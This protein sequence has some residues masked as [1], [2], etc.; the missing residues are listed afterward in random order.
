MPAGKPGVGKRWRGLIAA[1]V[2]CAGLMG[3]TAFAAFPNSAPNDPDYAPSEQGTQATC[4]QR[5]ADDEQHYLYSFMPKCSPNATDA[6]NS[7]G[8]SLDKAWRK[9]TPGNGHTVIAYIEGGI[10]W[11]HDPK[12]LADKVF[13]NKGELPPPT[14]P[15]K[16]KKLCPDALCAA[17]YSDTKDANKNGVVDPEDIIVR[18]SNRRD[19][20]SNGYVDDI[21]GWD[22]YND[23]NDPATVDSTYDHAN[24]QQ[25]QAAAQTDNDFKGAGVCPGCM[26]LPIK[27]G[28]EALDRTDDLAQAWLYAADLNADVLVSTTADLG[29]SSFMRQAVERVW[30]KGTIMAESSNDF[31]SIDHQGGMFWQHVLPGNG[32]V[33]NTHGFDIAPNSA[34]LQNQL[35]TTY[36]SR[37]GYTSW[38]T[39]NMFSAAT[40]GGT[41]SESVPTVG[42]VMAMVVAY[43]KK[44]AKQ[45][46]IKRPL[47]PD[48]AIQVVRATASDVAQNPCAP[49]CWPAKP[50]WDMQYGYGRPNVYK[51]MQ[52]ISKGNIPPEA[53]IDSP[54]W[55]SL[56]DPTKTDGVAVKGHIEA[57]RSKKPYTWKLQFAPG[58]E[59]SK[60][61]FMTAAQGKRRQALDGKLGQIDFSRLPPS[62]WNEAQ[63]PFH[64]SNTKELETNDQYTVTIRLRVI[65]AKGRMAEDR[66]AIAVHHDPTLR[67]GFPKRIGPGGE[68]QPVLADLQGRGREAIIFGDSDGR[69]HALS[70]HGRELPGFPVHTKPTKVTR[71]HRGI[72]PGY[73]PIFTN[74]A[75][76]D[77]KGNGKQW[78]VAT[79]STGRT[80]V[81][82]AH[83]HLMKGWPKGIA[84]GV[85]KPA[86]P[87]P[88]RPFTRP[89]VMGASAPPVLANLDGDRQLEIVQAGWDGYLHAWN[90]SGKKVKGWPVKVTLPPGTQPP[91]GMVRI[92][93]HK[94]DLPPTLAELDGDPT[95]ELVQR[96]QYAFTPGAG[97]QVGNGGIS[98]VV[99]YNSDG[100]RVPGFLLQ[101]RALA[102]Y[103]GSAQEFITEGV[104]SPATA[105][106]DGD[107]KTEIAS[108]A[109]IFTPT[110]LYNTDGSLRGAYGP[111][112][113]GAVSI[114]AGNP[115]TLIDVLHGNLPDDVPVNFATAGAFAS[116]GPGG[117]LAYVEPGSGSAS[118]VGALLL[119]GSGTPINSY[120]RAYG[121]ASLN[122]LPGFPTKAQGLDFL[123][124]P[125][126]AD[127]TGDGRP[128]VIQGGDSS[129]L[130]AFTS[131]GTQAPGF[132]KFTT[133]WVVFGPSVGDLDGNG[134][135][136]VAAATREGYLMVW[137]TRGR[138][139]TNDQWWS[140]RH[141][142]RNTGM[143]G[144]DTRPP[145][146]LRRVRSLHHRVSFKAP[147]DDWY[148]G[149]VDHYRVA[150]VRNP[151]KRH[152]H[153]KARSFPATVAAGKTQKLELPRRL[154]P[155]SMW[156]VDEAG[157]RGRAY[158]FAYPCPVSG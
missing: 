44:A 26:L 37:S 152:R 30:D 3:G 76:G 11:H 6:E 86:I 128:E 29:Y 149:K 139:D 130:H 46:K 63:N 126:V 78:I 47:S 80:Y 123:G 66:R 38:G 14:T 121:A 55:Y 25:E 27:A 142:E 114:A 50:G 87:R 120:M 113:G 41:T 5:P 39:H 62:F 134:T 13:L 45:G 58:A 2:C 84:T 74:V 35:T 69:L 9:F 54:R 100:S 65:D 67:A 61:N 70:P 49:N 145:G 12:E 71:P 102:F 28:A 85:R 21:S 153:P 108:A 131:T 157:N 119:A 64:L 109:G 82:N 124:E 81:W 106:V 132:P 127:V 96:T 90:P 79:T 53:W 143:Y 98:N 125:V 135:N 105:D 92:N 20:D 4:L 93:D 31:D 137:N 136:E 23:Q 75:V 148:D 112:P 24:N 88:A 133:G 34:A 154:S 147:G 107:G 94:L 40:Q 110:S 68:S 104:N 32:L 118:V 89:P 111:F 138:A 15:V 1:T 129:A 17:D 56:Y 10:N 36:R 97:L 77:L 60:A 122:P 72:D 151:C 156:A 73:E 22:F 83:G 155:V 103:Y 43:G 117:S 8:M 141:D 115:Q 150:L 99:A 101:G 146:V 57:P 158:Q 42:G 18:F 7:A 59:P 51:A 16:G 144:I 91:N 95:P 48:E 116:F 33:A 140:V 52:A 19:D